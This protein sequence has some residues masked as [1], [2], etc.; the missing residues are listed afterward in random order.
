MRQTGQ[1]R[2]LNKWNYDKTKGRYVVL[3]KPNPETRRQVLFISKFVR[4]PPRN[5]K[6]RNLERLEWL[7]VKI[8]SF[9]N[10]YKLHLR[11]QWPLGM[12]DVLFRLMCGVFLFFIFFYSLQLLCPIM[13][14]GRAWE[15]IICS[16]WQSTS[17]TLNFRVAHDHT[18]LLAIL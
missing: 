18:H 6:D 15:D 11:L 16:G 12:C 2:I 4:Q 8:Q 7:G 1:N 17:S 9:P 5:S 13:E 3:S 14:G 10:S